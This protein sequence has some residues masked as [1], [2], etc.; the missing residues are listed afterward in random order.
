[1]PLSPGV[2]ATLPARDQAGVG[3]D[4]RIDR[5]LRGGAGDRGERLEERRRVDAAE[6]EAGV[7]QRVDLL[8]HFVGQRVERAAIAGDV[9]VAGRDQARP[10]CRRLIAAVTSVTPL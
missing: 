4:G 8:H 1:M 2:A 5:D 10:P 9:D 6:R 3:G 7:V